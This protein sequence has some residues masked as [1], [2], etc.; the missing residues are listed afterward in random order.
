MNN[1]QKNHLKAYGIAYKTIAN[2]IYVSWLLNYEGGSFLMKYNT[3]TE[4]ECN[5]RGVT[6]N[7]IADHK[8]ESNFKRNKISREKSRYCE[9]R[10]SSKNR[11]L[12]SKK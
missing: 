10:K 8:S 7:I 1:D 6:Y 3:L 12:F 5:I 9:I 4:K 2:D 11:N